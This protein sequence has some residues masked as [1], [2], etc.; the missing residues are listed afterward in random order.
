M[1]ID[2]AFQRIINFLSTELVQHYSKALLLFA[3]GIPLSIFIANRAQRYLGQRYT[4]QHGLIAGQLFRWGGCILFVTAG[5][6]QLGFSLTPLLG[7][8][9]VVGVGIGIASQTSASNIIS[10]LFILIEEPFTI[11]DVIAVEQTTGE[12]LSIDLLSVK[13]RSFSNEFIRIPHETLLKNKVTNFTRFP[14]RRVEIDI[15]IAYKEDVGEVKKLIYKI[16]EEDLRILKIP[17]PFISF[18]GFGDSAVDLTLLVWVEKANY[19]AVKN[20]LPENIKYCFDKENIEIPLPHIKLL[21]SEQNHS[22]S[23]V[24][25]GFPDIS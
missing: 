21:Q 10:G 14:I 24:A 17:E 19:F 4:V 7:A 18:K 1:A 3:L 8:A 9:G 15:P 16:I 22:H 5:L 13:V 11:G 12:V 6:N 20:A 23:I 25:G 2:F